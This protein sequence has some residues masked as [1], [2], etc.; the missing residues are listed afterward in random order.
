MEEKNAK[1]EKSFVDDAMNWFFYYDKCLKAQLVQ[2]Q[3][4]A[5]SVEELKEMY[6]KWE[7]SIKA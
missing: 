4:A 7:N 2:P 3:D 1:V 6:E 5:Y